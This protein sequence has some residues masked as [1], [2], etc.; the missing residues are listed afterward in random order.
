MGL[1]WAASMGFS[2]DMVGREWSGS[3][4]RLLRVVEEYGIL[5]TTCVKIPGHPADQSDGS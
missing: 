1:C 2:R 5:V 4:E 3:V